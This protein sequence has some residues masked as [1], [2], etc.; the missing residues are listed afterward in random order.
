MTE[1]SLAKIAI[2]QASES[3]LCAALERVN[4]D[5]SGGRV[6][7]TDLASSLIIR[8]IQSLDEAGI[9][10]IR[11][12]HFNQVMYLESLIKKLKANH[13]ESLDQD[14]VSSLQSILGYQSTKRR[15][16]SKVSPQPSVDD[17]SAGT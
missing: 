15:R 3:D 16:T 14:E 5:F 8:A 1:N 13:R 4:K 11:Q 6:T 2:S 7:K 10:E 12:A 17:A 9:E